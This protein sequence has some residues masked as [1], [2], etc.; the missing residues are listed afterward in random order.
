MFAV[1]NPYGLNWTHTAG[2]ISQ[3]RRQRHGDYDFRLLQTTAAINPG[4]SGGGLYDSEGR[5]IGINT[6]TSDKRFAEGL[7]FSISLP[8]LLDLAPEKMDLP[9]RNPKAEKNQ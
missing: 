2:D 6:M 7:G 4:N 5:L 9:K 1:G 8:T 3:V